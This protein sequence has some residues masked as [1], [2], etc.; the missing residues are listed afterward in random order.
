[1]TGNGNAAIIPNN[2]VIIPI[3]EVIIPNTEVI[4]PVIDCEAKNS[5]CTGEICFNRLFIIRGALLQHLNEDIFEMELKE[6][7]KMTHTPASINQLKFSL[8]T[9]KEKWNR[10]EKISL[11]MQ[12]LAT[13]EV[14]LT[15]EVGFTEFLK[16]RIN[17][18]IFKAEQIIKRYKNCN[19]K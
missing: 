11:K 12:E 18:M 10:I 5:S 6:A 1:M 15:A 2:E 8:S 4:V 3:N 19:S 7:D 13:N 17:R 9:L 14:Q 16:D